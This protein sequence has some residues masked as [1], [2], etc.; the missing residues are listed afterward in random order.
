M[1]SG[2]TGIAAPIF[3]SGDHV[4]GSLSL[5]VGR[6]GLSPREVSEIATRVAFCAQVVSSALSAQENG[7]LTPLP[8]AVVGAQR[9]G[10][11]ARQGRQA[12]VLLG[13]Q[14]A[15]HHLGAEGHAGGDLGH[16]ARGQAGAADGQ[17]EAAHH[18]IPRIE[19]RGGDAGHAGH[20]LALGGLPAALADGAQ[21]RPHGLE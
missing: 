15:R 16:L 9:Q 5:T 20:H 19:D 17:A 3:D 10:V 6:T 7:G 1:V 21:G 18:V 2:V 8:G 14:G 13:R 12:P 11:G 4:M